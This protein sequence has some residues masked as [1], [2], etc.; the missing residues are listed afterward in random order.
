MKCYERMDFDVPVGRERTM[1]HDRY[2]C[3]VERD[4][5]GEPPSSVNGLEW[6]ARA[7]LSL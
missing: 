5:Q 3:R 1:T 7:I 4:A 2:W 6:S